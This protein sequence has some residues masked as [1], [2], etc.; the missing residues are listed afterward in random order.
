MIKKRAKAIIGLILLC[1]AIGLAFW[2][3]H[4][5]VPLGKVKEGLILYL[6]SSILAIVALWFIDECLS[7]PELLHRNEKGIIGSQ[8][9]SRKN[10]RFFSITAM[11]L[12]LSSIVASLYL[13]EYNKAYFYGLLAWVASLVLLSL[14]L[15]AGSKRK[16]NFKPEF[17]H[18]KVIEIALVIVI[19][20]LALTA[21]LPFLNDI[22]QNVHV[23]EAA[24]GTSAR[25]VLHGDV[26]NV[27]STGWA[28]IPNMSYAIS[29]FFM[30]IFG[31]NLYGLRMASVIQGV[32]S[33]LLF[34]LIIRRLFSAR[35]A[36]IS[37]SLLAVSQFHIHFSRIGTDYLQSSFAGLLLFYFL[38]SGIEKQRALYFLFA[39]FAAALCFEVYYA[40]RI[41]PVVAGLYLGHCIIMERGFLKRNW[42]GI[43]S[44]AL[45]AIIFIAPLLLFYSH[46]PDAFMQRTKQVVIFTPEAVKY[47]S[48][49]YNVD[50]LS[51]VLQVHI[52]RSV[53]AFNLYGETSTQYSRLGPLLDF[54]T[55]ALFVLGLAV[56]TFRI[57]NSRYFLLAST[58]WVILFGCGVITD[59]ALFSPR[60]IGLVPWLFVFPAII[61]DAGW[62][63]FNFLYEKPGS[64]VFAVLAII[65]ISLAAYSNYQD[66]FAN[67]AQS[68]QSG[69]YN[70]LLSRYL[71]SINNDYRIYLISAFGNSLGAATQHFLLP[72]V[73]GVDI[74]DGGELALPLDRVP[75]KKGVAFIVDINVP[76]SDKR[77]AEIKII[78]P[79]GK[80]EFHKTY[81][82]D[83]LFYSYFVD[84]EQLLSINSNATVDKERIPGL[85]PHEMVSQPVR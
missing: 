84:S 48:Q 76:K 14:S 68:L 70:T 1:L 17:T 29:A 62:R 63:G 27:F 58:F 34:Y 55:S 80:E 4:L 56:S 35:V 44:I 52:K 59:E 71:M 16:W 39:G 50:G 75:N 12:G 53:L 57:K 81:K 78:Y 67:P 19:L 7:V 2:A 15:W 41:I 28:A 6:F 60:V 36:I 26:K 65:F 5:L 37:S 83:P 72:D 10:F 47:F 73:D 23:D 30:F 74:R 51:G 8:K 61:V 82:G 20:V 18:A 32:I 46:Y 9:I 85:M 13:I 77:L 31:D 25:A 45:G 22:P 69:T 40:S 11:V 21:R 64:Y 38:L 33:I 43:L 3:Q 66:Y 49:K 54:W 42:K 24:V 79:E